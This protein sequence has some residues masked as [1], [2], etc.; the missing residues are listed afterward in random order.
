V[1]HV[2]GKHQFRAGADFRQ[3]TRSSHA[4]NSDG[5]FGFGNT[6]FRQ[7][8]DA[9][10]SGTYNPATVGL[11]WASFM[12]GLPTSASVSNNASFLASNQFAAGFIQDTWRATNRLT[13]TLSLRGEWENGAKD[14]WPNWISGWNSGAVLPISALAQSAY[15]SNP[16]PE[17]PASNFVVQGG[18]M[19]AGTPG[20]P[21]PPPQG[22]CPRTG[23]PEPI[24]PELIDA[25]Y[26]EASVRSAA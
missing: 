7:Y 2:V 9:G 18:P 6:Y 11:S 22:R 14:K 13:L 16:I 19:Y 10:P 1:Y 12:M 4:G 8:D 25:S 15:S 26:Q 17:L 24:R 5:T 3:E 20:A 23:V 21:G